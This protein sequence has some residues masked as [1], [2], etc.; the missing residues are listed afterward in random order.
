MAVT[1]AARCL[2]ITQ[3]RITKTSACSMTS[4]AL[5]SGAVIL[6]IFPFRWCT[7]TLGAPRPHSMKH[8]HKSNFGRK[9]H[10]CRMLEHFPEV[11]GSAAI[12][13][14]PV[15]GMPQKMISLCLSLSYTATSFGYDPCLLIS[16]ATFR[17]KGWGVNVYEK[18]NGWNICSAQIT[19]RPVPF[20]WPEVG[21]TMVRQAVHA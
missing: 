10:A 7:Q 5:H 16:M 18:D 8:V 12:G 6:C 21:M 3:T 11:S 15:S 14:K 13:N 17:A 1:S 4:H 9:A 20:A 19:P 2:L